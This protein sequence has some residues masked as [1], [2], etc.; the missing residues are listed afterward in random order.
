MI[1][2]FLDINLIKFPIYNCNSIC[3][4][5]N[6][7]ITKGVLKSDII[8]KTFT[9][10]DL[11]KY[12][13]DYVCVD[14]ALLLSRIIKNDKG[15]YNSIRNYSFYCDNDGYKLLS[16]NEIL[17]LLLNLKT[18]KFQICITFK[19]KK[20]IAYRSK[21]QLNNKNF[22]VTTDIGQI[23]FDVKLTKSILPIIQSWFTITNDTKQQPTYFNKS[24]ILGLSIPNFKKIN[25]YGIDK[26]F[27]EN[28]ILDKYRDT[29]YF[30]LL[31]HI[32][33]KKT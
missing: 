22:I 14:I 27:N 29:L 31:I 20:H 28:F 32:L 16:R 18:N 30:K 12:K 23:L 15:N 9:D 33:N 17:D 25:A 26:Y 7:Q 3:A 24:D 1:T 11:I 10:F 6:K 19:N 8:S 5:T 21:I 2:K 13:S 4:F